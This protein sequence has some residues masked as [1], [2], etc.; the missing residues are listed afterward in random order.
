MITD[1]FIFSMIIDNHFRESISHTSL[2]LIKDL[3]VSYPNICHLPVVQNQR[4]TFDLVAYL[5]SI[6]IQPTQVASESNLH[7]GWRPKEEKLVEGTIVGVLKFTYDHVD[8]TVFKAEWQ[9]NCGPE[10]FYDFAFSAPDDAVGKKLLSA[11]FQWS[12]CLKEEMWVFE[13]GMW[14][15][16][17]ELYAA[18]QAASWDEIVL[19]ESFKDNIRRDTETFF[20]NKEIYR[21]LGI[22]W[23]R[24]LLLLGPPGNGKTESIKALLHE[25][26]KYPALYV[27][28]ITTQSV[29]VEHSMVARV[30]LTENSYIGRRSRRTADLPARQKPLTV[31]SRL[32][33]S[34]L[35][36]DG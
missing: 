14:H 13:G 19:D 8:F 1:Y 5:G 27:K 36:P 32:G 18:V 4:H 33:R 29:S 2:T 16:N 34:G 15:K 26:S 7:Y 20:A 9:G 22:T 23:K 24:G 3:K 30:S 21:S 31:Y 35:R 12:N 28:S 25:F 10:I 17:K 11:I 6:G